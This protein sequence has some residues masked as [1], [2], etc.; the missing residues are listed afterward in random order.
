MEKLAVTKAQKERVYRLFEKTLD[1]SI[2][3]E[4]LDGNNIEA[5]IAKGD[6]FQIELQNVF[7]KIF[8]KEKFE[9]EQEYS[10]SGYV[11][12][13]SLPQ[14]KIQSVSLS[15]QVEILN[16]FFSGIGFVDKKIQ[17]R[18][19]PYGAETWFVIPRWQLFAETR[20]AATQKIFE[21]ISK[22]ERPLNWDSIDL[23]EF[24]AST[25]LEAKLKEIGGEQKRYDYLVVAAQFGFLHRGQSPRRARAVF[26]SNE[27]GLG[28]FEVICMILTHPS[29]FGLAY[30]LYC[31]CP[32]EE[33]FDGFV[34]YFKVKP[35]GAL[36]CGNKPT[37]IYL[38]GSGSATAFK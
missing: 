30:D 27:F 7:C 36:F 18:M 20:S 6:E 33:S 14:G 15:K 26:Q 19:L 9:K 1:L 37:D 28:A 34:P 31:D 17:K 35:N 38:R 2:V 12:G 29:R 8:P 16:E 3:E 11:G 22:K 13:Y 5:L 25:R 10:A 4:C 23:E 21:M 32:G 24:S